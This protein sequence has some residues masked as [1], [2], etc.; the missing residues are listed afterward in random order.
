[1]GG[2]RSVVVGS[3][4]RCC[5]FEVGMELGNT[6]V[7]DWHPMQVLTACCCQD[8]RAVYSTCLSLVAGRTMRNTDIQSG[9]E[10]APNSSRTSYQ[11]QQQAV[12]DPH[13]RSCNTYDVERSIHICSR[14]SQSPFQAS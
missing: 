9:I 13:P 6:N 10:T 11:M 7:G 2:F 5:S 12:I 3:V 8:V 14:F 4:D 1:M